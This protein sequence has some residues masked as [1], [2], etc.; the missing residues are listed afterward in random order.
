M[1]RGKKGFTLIE[2]LVVIAIIA[3]LIA[4]LLPAVQAAREAARRTECKNHMKQLGLALHN[5]HDT[6]L[7][8]PPG[9]LTMNQAGTVNGAS[10]G[11]MLLPYC[12][13]STIYDLV[14]FNLPMTNTAAPQVAP[15]RNFDQII[16]VLK[17]FQ[18]PSSGDPA[19]VSSDRGK[20]T[21]GIAGPGG[22]VG[23]NTARTTNAATANYLACSGTAMND[24]DNSLATTPLD[25]GGCL[26]EESRVK[27]A[28]IVDGTNNTILIAEHHSRTCETGGGNTNY[29]DQDSCYG[30]W[31]NADS[32]TT[33]ASNAT[34]AA[35]VACSSLYGVNGNG[36]TNPFG[37]RVGSPGDISSNHEAGAQITLGDGSVR[38]ISN[39]IDINVLNNLAQRADLNVVSF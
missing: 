19:T 35:D 32:G 1:V 36:Q 6:N 15:N 39:S 9:W 34:C 28:D 4:L 17:L 2:L 22:T 38:F 7:V 25:N 3:I 14:N 26:F 5:Y 31:S 37:Q 30:Y 18:C 11:M 21:T 23:D 20:C 8:F 33:V 10:W 27:I 12:E 16:T 24:G 29:A 13:F